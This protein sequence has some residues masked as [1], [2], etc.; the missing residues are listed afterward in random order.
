MKLSQADSEQDSM[1]LSL[2]NPPQ[3]LFKKD[4][5]GYDNS[6]RIAFQNGFD[7]ENSTPQTMEYPPS[8]NNNSAQWRDEIQPENMNEAGDGIDFLFN[9]V[10][11][12]E[13]TGDLQFSGFGSG[14]AGDGGA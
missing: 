13:T 5:K 9:S 1:F 6:A 8:N 2:N 4:R 3:P 14:R 10:Y 7:T 11:D 12:E